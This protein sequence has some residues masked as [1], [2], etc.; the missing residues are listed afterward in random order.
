[1]NRFFM[2]LMIALMLAPLAANAA[3]RGIN[4][5]QKLAAQSGVPVGNYRALIIGINDYADDKIPDLQTAAV[6][7]QSV[8]TSCASTMV[9][10][11]SN[12]CSMVRPMVPASIRQ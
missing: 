11:I 3:D 1:M 5:R 12:C 9:S 7:A 4:I 8:P 10:R 2:M 6:D